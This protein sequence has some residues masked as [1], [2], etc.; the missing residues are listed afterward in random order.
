MISKEILTNVFKLT[1]ILVVGVV[2]YFSWRFYID[3]YA[4]KEG[5]FGKQII[6]KNEKD[7][8]SGEEA[9]EDISKMP[10]DAEEE[11]SGPEI[12]DVQSLV[13]LKPQLKI[14]D[15]PVDYFN[16]RNS[17]SLSGQRIGRVY[18]GE[19]YKYNREE[20]GWY[21]I[22]FIDGNGWVFGKYVETIIE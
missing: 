17:P 21:E 15:T 14:L 10:K 3:N 1:I 4:E 20:N 22:V 18:P 2:I 19:K 7:G 11:S 13:L 12:Q 6:I 5:G 9:S 16:V 8:L